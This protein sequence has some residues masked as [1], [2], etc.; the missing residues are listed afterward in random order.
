MQAWEGL[1]P[2][3]LTAHELDHL[4]LQ[5]IALRNLK[6]SS[7]YGLHS[8]REPSLNTMLAENKINVQM[9]W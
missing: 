1:E 5:H 8:L 4:L 2:P 6:L 7:T 9:N 3:D